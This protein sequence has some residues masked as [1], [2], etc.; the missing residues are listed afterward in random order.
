MVVDAAVAPSCTETGL[1]EGSHCSRCDY[2]V[3][4]EEV[5]ATGHTYE[6][7]KCHCGAEDPDYVE[8]EQPGEEKPE[9]QPE[10]PGFFQRI[11]KAIVDFFK[12]I[13]GKIT[14]IFPKK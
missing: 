10:Q 12:S 2:K 7:G 8:P 5:P 1:T 4:Q 9:P 13:I 3:A 11:W 14:S 6:N